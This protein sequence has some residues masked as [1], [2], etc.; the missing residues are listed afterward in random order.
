MGLT[1]KITVFDSA[2]L[3][4]VNKLVKFYNFTTGGT[5][6]NL[7][8]YLHTSSSILEAVGFSLHGDDFKS[9]FYS[10]CGLAGSLVITGLFMHN[11]REKIEK[12]DELSAS[13]VAPSK[14][15]YAEETSMG[16]LFGLFGTGLSIEKFSQIG[17]HSDGGNSFF[18]CSAQ[19][20]RSLAL[21]VMRA[22]SLPPRKN[23]LSRIINKHKSF[24]SPQ[25]S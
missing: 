18:I 5:K 17:T 9:K 25:Y 7:S 20:I 23:I 15:F 13:G 10:V 24:Y 21:H 11:N 3:H 6:D 4:G 1:E 14:S 16:Y 19:I 22:E 12:E 8:D 2:V